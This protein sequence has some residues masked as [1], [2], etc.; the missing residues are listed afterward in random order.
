MAAAWSGI[1]FS[2]VHQHGLSLKHKVWIQKGPVARHAPLVTVW[3]DAKLG[4][5]IAS[6]V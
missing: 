5:P 3:T 6:G 1:A 2:G 4:Q